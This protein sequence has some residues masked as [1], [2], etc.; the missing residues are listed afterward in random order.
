MTSILSPG[1]RITAIAQDTDE[2][3]NLVFVPGDIYFVHHTTRAA[4]DVNGDVWIAVQP[5]FLNGETAHIKRDNVK[6]V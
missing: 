6:A 5:A 4:A 1:T 2:D 3:A